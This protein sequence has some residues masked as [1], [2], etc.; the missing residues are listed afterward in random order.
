MKKLIVIIQFDYDD[1]KDIVK[2]QKINNFFSR[3]LRKI[4]TIYF[5]DFFSPFFLKKNN[6]KEKSVDF[7]FPIPFS[8]CAPIFLANLFIFK[9][10][11]FIWKKFSTSN[12]EKVIFMPYRLFQSLNLY[13]EDFKIYL[14][15]R[16]Y[17]EIIQ[18]R[19][20]ALL[21]AMRIFAIKS[22]G[23]FVSNLQGK[24]Y[25]RKFTEEIIYL[26]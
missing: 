7:F 3:N 22:V 19:E 11:L 1:E 18:K 26:L 4:E 24:K 12:K 13:T 20:V 17:L 15:C 25:W 23:V 2:N 10:S 6:D 21:E 16:S 14:D 8:R 9:C 5:R